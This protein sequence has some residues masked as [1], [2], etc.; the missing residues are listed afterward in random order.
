ML[1]PIINPDFEKILDKLQFTN[2]QKIEASHMR[3]EILIFWINVKEGSSRNSCLICRDFQLRFISADYI[4]PLTSSKSSQP[5]VCFHDF[6]QTQ[7]K[8]I[9]TSDCL[10]GAFWT[11]NVSNDYFQTQNMFVLD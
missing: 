2:H 8:I 11:W 4:V 5:S 10:R 9:L 3:M 6:I 7:N 1:N